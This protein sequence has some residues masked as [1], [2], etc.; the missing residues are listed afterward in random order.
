MS[1][2]AVEGDDVD[3]PPLDCASRRLQAAARAAQ[4]R[5]RTPIDIDVPGATAA[6]IRNGVANQAAT[7]Q[8]L[9]NAFSRSVHPQ[10]P[11]RPPAPPRPGGRP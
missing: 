8:R 5:A 11:N 7:R 3:A 6:D 10:R 4:K 1:C 9:G 2:V